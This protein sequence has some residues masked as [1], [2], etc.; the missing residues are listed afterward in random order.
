M[1]KKELEKF[2]KKLLKLKS[3]LQKFIELNET[4]ADTDY[5]IDELDQ[6]TNLIEKMTGFAVSSNFRNNIIKVEEALQRIENK[7]FGKCMNCNKD[8]SLKRLK[9]LPFTQYCI[10]CQREF[11]KYK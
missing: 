1:D 8:I 2:K 5:S 9:V 11:E 6:A 3:E 4:Y 10:D 7:K